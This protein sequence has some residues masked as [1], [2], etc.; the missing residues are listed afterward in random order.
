MAGCTPRRMPPTTMER[1]GT[2]LAPVHRDDRGMPDARTSGRLS[3]P[4]EV[5]GPLPT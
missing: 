1:A 4:K 3:P 2:L 5:R